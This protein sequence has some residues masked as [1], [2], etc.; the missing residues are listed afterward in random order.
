MKKLILT[1]ALSLALI[2]LSKAQFFI[3]S[4]GVELGW[5]IPNNV[6]TVI[7]HDYYGYDVI[8]ANRVIRYGH[9]YF[10]LILQQGDIFVDISVR[11]D[12]FISR[13]LVSYDYPLLG[14]ICG[15]QCGYHSNYYVAYNNHCNSHNHR[16]HNHVVYNYNRPYRGHAHHNQQ[17]V[18]HVNYKGN[19]HSNGRGHNKHIEKHNN[20]SDKGRHNKD[21]RTAYENKSRRSSDGQYT[22]RSRNYEVVNN[23]NGRSGR[24]AESRSSRS[25]SN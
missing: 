4:F 5:N 8:H 25:R 13:R 10:D 6:S 15:N 16:G 14:H 22:R 1:F 20:R 24:S 21:S 17:R 9:S 12:G 19:H 7:H 18:T 11:N 2:S 23:S 3:T